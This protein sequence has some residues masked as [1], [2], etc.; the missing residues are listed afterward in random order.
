MRELFSI[1]LIICWSIFHTNH[2]NVE[3]DDWV[4]FI[5]KVAS[6]L[7]KTK[8]AEDEYPYIIS[9]NSGIEGMLILKAA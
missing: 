2:Y 6:A 8:N 5:K 1:L 9:E 7:E 3:H 4:A